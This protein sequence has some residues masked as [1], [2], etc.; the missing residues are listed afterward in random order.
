MALG[1]QRKIHP[2][3][4]AVTCGRDVNPYEDVYVIFPLVGEVHDRWYTTHNGNHLFLITIQWLH[5]ATNDSE[6]PM[7]LLGATTAFP[8]GKI[9]FFSNLDQGKTALCVSNLIPGNF[10]TCRVGPIKLVPAITFRFSL[11]NLQK[12]FTKRGNLVSP[13]IGR[14]L[15]SSLLGLRLWRRSNHDGG[16]WCRGNLV[17]PNI[18]I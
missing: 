2:R 6:H 16:E 13:N 10:T 9:T 8:E 14:E 1:P 15:L 17:S 18:A 4:Y 11:S 3:S 5:S 12:E 7:S